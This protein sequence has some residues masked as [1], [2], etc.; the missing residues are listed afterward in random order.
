MAAYTVDLPEDLARFVEEQVAAGA[1]LDAAAVLRSAVLRHKWRADQ[2]EARE[3]R[4]RELVQEGVDELD[5]GEGIL[6]ED[7]EAF[8]KQI[9]DEVEA[10]IAAEDAAYAA[11][12]AGK[13]A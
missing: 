7:I 5:R 8:C 3:R 6:V 11:H 10:E 1:Y 12:R 9:G 2:Q 4:F 13:A